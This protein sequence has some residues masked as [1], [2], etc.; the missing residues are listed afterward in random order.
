MGL[1]GG[2][3]A[4]FA[5]KPTTPVDTDLGIELG[6]ADRARGTG[7]VDSSGFPCPKLLETVLAAGGGARRVGATLA[8]TE[9][10]GGA[11]PLGG[12]G[13]ACVEAVA[14]LGSFLLTHLFRSLS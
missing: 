13:V 9:R 3:A 1:F 2:P 14:L 12:G 5:V 4:T 8:L 7:P 10:F 11:G 6:S